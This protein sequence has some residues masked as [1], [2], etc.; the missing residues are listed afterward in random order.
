[1]KKKTIEQPKNSKKKRKVFLI[2][3]GLFILAGIVLQ[4]KNFDRRT[5]IANST[6]SEEMEAIESDEE[7]NPDISVTYK[8]ENEMNQQYGSYLTEH[9]IDFFAGQTKIKL[10]SF[11]ESPELIFQNNKDNSKYFSISFG[12]DSYEEY[13]TDTEVYRHT[14][15]N[16][17]ELW[18]RSETGDNNEAFHELFGETINSIYLDNVISLITENPE[19]RYQRTLTIGGVEE[20]DEFAILLSQEDDQKDDGVT[21]GM[22][23]EE[24]KEYVAR[25]EEEA[26]VILDQIEKD[27]ESLYSI[28]NNEI[29]YVNLYIDSDTGEIKYID[30]AY[31]ESSKAQI[32]FDSNPDQ[33]KLPD[34]IE[35]N[36]NT[37]TIDQVLR[38]LLNKCASN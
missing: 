21:S 3:L 32:I 31:G 26:K 5:E 16:S 11:Y 18:G 33:K 23:D 14:I 2:L 30:T 4:I 24:Y 29:G 15:S 10:T 37:D 34:N 28:D 20:L 36:N 25:L 35:V 17:E 9:P 8:D 38:D 22:T 1:M 6:S 13:I 27:P 19:I 7:A 12:G